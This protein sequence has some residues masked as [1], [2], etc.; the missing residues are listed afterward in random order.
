[1]KN[2]NIA[3]VILH[4]ESLNDTINCLRSL[5]KYLISDSI[6][7]I[8]VDNGSRNEKLQTISDDYKNNSKV[9]FLYSDRNLG[10]AKGNNLG[11]KFAKENYRPDIIVLAN[12]DLYFN[13]DEFFDILVKHYKEDKFDV[14]GPRII[15]LKD[16]KNQNPVGIVYHKTSEVKMRI[17]K[18]KIL[19]ILS[20]FNLDVPCKKIF[21]KEIPEY[22]LNDCEDFQLHGACMAFGKKYIDKFDGLYSGTFMYGEEPILKYIITKEKMLM[23]YYDDIEVYHKEGSSTENF[24]GKGKKQRQFFYHWSINSLKQLV[25]MMKV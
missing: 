3:V 5:D 10:F 11:F 24:Y 17:L 13:Q 9:R 20:H 14:A 8:A 2:I 23:K 25:D 19:N 21:A 7:I 18:L 22:R 16:G 12:N 15:S 1:M 4:F 6:H